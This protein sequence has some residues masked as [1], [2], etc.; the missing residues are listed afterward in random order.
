MPNI[1]PFTVRATDIHYVDN[2]RL[3]VRL[4]QRDRN[5]VAPELIWYALDLHVDGPKSVEIR[6]HDIANTFSGGIGEVIFT[7][8]P[9]LDASDLAALNG[10]I[11]DKQTEYAASEFE[12]RERARVTSEIEAIRRE[13]F[14]PAA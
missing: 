3:A 14:E 11:V 13:L 8:R 10:L 5:Q 6:V 2:P 9:S 7:Y 4:W 1:F 12:R